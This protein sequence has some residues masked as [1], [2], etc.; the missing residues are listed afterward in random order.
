MWQ[1]VLATILYNKRMHEKRMAILRLLYEQYRENGLNVHANRL[2]TD[3]KA[4]LGNLND[5]RFHLRALIDANLV[6]GGEEGSIKIKYPG[7]EYYEHA[8]KPWR[9]KA[10]EALTDP[11]RFAG[12]IYGAASS[13]FGV[14][15]GAAIGY[16]LGTK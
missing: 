7:L 4:I 15:I 6:E 14:I 9:Q 8:I 5:Y 11:V 13:L 3:N 2:H 1:T 12:F 10:R 16:M